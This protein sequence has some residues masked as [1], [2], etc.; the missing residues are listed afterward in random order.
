MGKLKLLRDQFKR[1]LTSINREKFVGVSGIAALT[2]CALMGLSPEAPE[3]IRIGIFSLASSLGVEVAGS[4][5]YDSYSW[6]LT[7]KTKDE[8]LALHELASRIER[9]IR[10]DAKLRIALGTFLGSED[11]N[12]FDIALE[13]LDENPTVNRWLLYQVYREVTLITR[14][15]KNLYPYVKE[16]LAT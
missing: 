12:A 2:A 9:E 13:I 6:L 15:F 4:V 14:D 10:Q 5:L 8:S 16:I 1:H 3:A 7:K 11:L